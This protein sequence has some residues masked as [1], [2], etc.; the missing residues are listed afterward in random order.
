MY[1]EII[2]YL[3]RKN[4]KYQEVSD[5]S[6]VH[7]G[8]SANNG[9]IDCV[10]DVRED[11]NQ[12]VFLSYCTVIAFKNK[13]DVIN[14]F[15]AR[16]NYGLLIGDFELNYDSGKIRFKTSMFFDEENTPTQNVIEKTIITNLYMMDLYLPGIM[17]VLYGAVSPKIAISQIEGGT[18]MLNLN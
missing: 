1:E 8:I 14:E 4:W 6:V 15:L 9:N 16:V 13:V 7:F 17:S 11:R 10:A 2:K 18:N 12:F 5:K 3:D